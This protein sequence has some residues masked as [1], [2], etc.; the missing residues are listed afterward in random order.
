VTPPVPP[1]REIVRL[2]PW[3]VS[4]AR[5][6]A[7]MAGDDHVRRWSSLADDVE[8]WLVRERAEARG[9]SRAIC[10][11]GDDRALGK[12]ALRL[13]GRA[14]PAAT[15]A[16]IVASDHPVAELSYWL[17]PAA[18]GR[19]LAHAAMVAMMR[20]IADTTDVRSVVLDIEE[21]NAASERLAVRL[22]AERRE[23]SR[24]ELDRMGV[25]RTLVV[26]VL[27]VAR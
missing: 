24:V 8:A 25:P 16:A 4:D 23:P 11:A 3:R 6:I 10:L 1:H 15:C 9:P 13:P 19:G 2:R 17:V 27:N 7:V 18:R 5:D 21:G 20:S 12:V 26:F 22:G 14:S